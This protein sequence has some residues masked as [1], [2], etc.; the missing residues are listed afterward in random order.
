MPDATHPTT[1]H[2]I[3]EASSLRQHRCENLS[4]GNCLIQTNLVKLK[5]LSFQYH[6]SDVTHKI[7]TQFKKK[8]LQERFTIRKRGCHTNF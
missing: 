6:V 8:S 7:R 2:H 5:A 4:S 1:R 3:P